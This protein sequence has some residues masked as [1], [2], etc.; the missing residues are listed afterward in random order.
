MK[1]SLNIFLR[2]VLLAAPVAAQAQLNYRTNGNTMSI[3][4]YTGPAGDLVIPA[5]INGM[6]VTTIGE[7]AFYN[8]ASLTSITMPAA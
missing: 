1:H 4:G 3:T 6:L 8:C 5:T 7:V 2:L